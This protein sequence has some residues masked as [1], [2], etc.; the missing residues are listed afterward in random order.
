MISPIGKEDSPER[1]RAD[2][3]LKYLIRRAIGD[4]FDVQRADE[5]VNPGAITPRIISSIFEADLIVADITGLNANVFYELAIAHGYGKPTVHL[6]EG[7]DRPPFD[8]KDMR[9]VAYDTTA[10]EKLEQAQKM[11][12]SFSDFAVSK[13]GEIETPLREARR[14]EA[15]QASGDPVADSNVQILEALQNLREQVATMGKSLGRRPRRPLSVIDDHDK[16]GLIRIV[17]RIVRAGRAE[18]ADFDGV[19]TLETSTSFDDWVQKHVVQ[20]DPALSQDQ[21]EDLVND[22]QM[23]A[24]GDESALIADKPPF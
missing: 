8:I 2:R 21:L 9:I 4:K 23:A 10:P 11:L 7:S 12:A 13:P 5:D 1:L 15:V 22:V 18:L 3:V 17:N 19:R 16:R 14:F 6:Q 20:I 24:A